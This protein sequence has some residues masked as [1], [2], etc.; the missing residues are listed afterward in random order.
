MHHPASFV[1]N[2]KCSIDI[3]ILIGEMEL[4][5]F[6][7]IKSKLCDSVA[8]PYSSE[9]IFILNF[10]SLLYVATPWDTCRRV[11]RAR[12][13]QWFPYRSPESQQFLLLPQVHETMSSPTPFQVFAII[14]RLSVVHASLFFSLLLRT[15]MS[16]E[17]G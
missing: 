11:L 17:I 1:L 15:V 16:G 12:M 8:W 13:E 7:L 5:Y 10:L 9:G 2:L 4:I 3:R 6:S 14:R